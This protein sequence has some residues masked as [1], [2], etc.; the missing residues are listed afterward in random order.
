M[1]QRFKKEKAAGIKERLLTSENT[2]FIF[3]RETANY[4]YISEEF[5]NPTPTA[6]YGNKAVIVVWEPLTIVMIENSE[7]AD[8]YR[9]Y[10]EMLWNMAGEKTKAASRTPTTMQSR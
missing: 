1:E 7:L 3:E 8:S 10:F 4:R 2:E 9:K 6:V 5:F